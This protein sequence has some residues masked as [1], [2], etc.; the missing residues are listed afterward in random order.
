VSLRAELDRATADLLDP[1]RPLDFRFARLLGHVLNPVVP[2]F[3]VALVSSVWH[4]GGLTLR[5]IGVAVLVSALTVGLPFLVMAVAWWLGWT[6]GDLWAVRRESRRFLYPAVVLGLLAGLVVFRVV[7]PFPLA[8]AMTASAAVV[9]SAMG[10][11]N[12]RAKVSLH[13]AGNAA[14]ATATFWVYGGSA[15]WLAGLVPIVAWARVRTGNHSVL[16]VLAG[17]IIGVLG[18]LACA[19]LLI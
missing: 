12:R 15:L 17:T 6:E 19:A 9:I 2:G 16:E 14:I 4:E 10:V 18:T 11:A 1:A 7:Y 5:L 8:A 3:C 13:C